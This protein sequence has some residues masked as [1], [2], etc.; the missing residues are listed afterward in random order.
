MGAGSVMA[1]DGLPSRALVTATCRTLQLAL[2][3]EGLQKC[4]LLIGIV[5]LMLSSSRA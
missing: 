4:P 1:R 2:T 5:F 3:V